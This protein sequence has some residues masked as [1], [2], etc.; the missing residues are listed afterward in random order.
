MADDRTTRDRPV[1]RSCE[2]QRLEEQLW[3]LAYQHLWPALR[4]KP[5]ARGPKSKQRSYDQARTTA[6]AR[7][8]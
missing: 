7:R 3:S 6:Q 4:N 8:V 1:H 2:R 5:K